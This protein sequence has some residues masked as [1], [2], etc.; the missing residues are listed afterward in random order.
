VR[1]HR[2]CVVQRTGREAELGD[3]GGLALD[4]GPGA[5]KVG[6]VVLI[7]PAFSASMKASSE[8]DTNAWM[9]RVR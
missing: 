8:V 6:E 9:V 3:A 1:G 4:A 7:L 2:A 5:A